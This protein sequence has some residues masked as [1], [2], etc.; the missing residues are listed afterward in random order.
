MVIQMH[1]Q[2]YLNYKQYT[3]LKARYARKLEHGI[4]HTLSVSQT[5]LFYYQYA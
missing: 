2:L 1:S 5:C 3:F 4:N